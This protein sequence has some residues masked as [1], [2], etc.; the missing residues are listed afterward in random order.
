MNPGAVFVLSMVKR[1]INGIR[2]K[3]EGQSRSINKTLK[4]NEVER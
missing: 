1:L 2:R 3:F 4:V